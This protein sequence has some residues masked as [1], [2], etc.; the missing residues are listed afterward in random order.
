ME[1]PM[2]FW[3]GLMGDD[4]ILPE[5]VEPDRAVVEG[6]G[7]TNET[8][9]LVGDGGVAA[10][11]EENDASSTGSCPDL[12]MEVPPPVSVPDETHGGA[13]AAPEPGNELLAAFE[14]FLAS[15]GEGS[16]VPQPPQPVVASGSGMSVSEKCQDQT[17]VVVTAKLRLTID[18]GGY[19]GSGDKDLFVGKTFET[20]NT[21]KQHMSLYDIKNKFVDRSAKSAPSVMV[22]EC[23]GQTCTW[24]VYAVLVK[25]SSMYEVRKIGGEHS[26]SIDERS[27][28][29]RQATSSVIGEM[30][31]QQF[32]GT[33]V[34]PRPREIRQ[35]MRGDHAVNISYWKAWRSREVAVDIAKGSCGASYQSLPNYL[36][37]LVVAN[38][39]TLGHIHTEYVED[40][41]H[42]FK[43]M[44]LA[45]GA[46]VKGF[47][48]MRKVVVIDGTHLRGKYAGCLLIASAQDGNY[49]IFPLA[50]AIVDGENDKSWESSH[51]PGERYNIMT[52]N[53]AESWNLVLRDEREYP[54]ILLVEFIRKKIMS[55]FTSR[56]DAIKDVEAGL[57]PKVSSFLA[58]NFE[59][60][61]GYDV[62][63]LSMPCS[64]AIAAALKANVK[65][66]G[67]IGDVYT[68]NYLKAAY[69]EHVLPP[70]ELDSGHRL[71]DDVASITL[72]P[73]ATRRPPGRPRKKR[74]FSHEE[75]TQ[76]V[77]Q[78]L[79]GAR[80]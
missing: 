73:P 8:I 14:K 28:Y 40:V 60:C 10:A 34:G 13:N 6:E 79:Q 61:G 62:R 35:V 32:S 11:H 53:L 46:C 59:I 21:F 75:D 36:Q 15:R 5:D 58:A 69:A 76:K 70:V 65:V 74:L 24:R 19:V 12:E 18:C 30:L 39:G 78:P 4:L 2:D 63:K 68:I 47:Q 56:R 52:S 20:R 26:C 45:M 43:Y 22:L 1:T 48:H 54:V 23:I 66:E 80:A 27:G 71:A 33:G 49:Q 31:R 37:R 55:W 77:L 42:R 17:T 72:N 67:L 3:E 64:H 51:F 25:G 29:Q 41:G 57:T 16:Q 38:P 9:C 50:F 44:F 7:R